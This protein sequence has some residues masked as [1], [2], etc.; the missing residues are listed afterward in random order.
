MALLERYRVLRDTTC[1]YRLS[2][3][4]WDNTGIFSYN[5]FEGFQCKYKTAAVDIDLEDLSKA[6][7]EYLVRCMSDCGITAWLVNWIAADLMERT[8]A[9]SFGT[10]TTEPMQIWPGLSEGSPYRRYCLT[11]IQCT[12]PK[13]NP[14]S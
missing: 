10:G 2:R 12:S 11:Y 5:V 6:N 8:L 1:S 4:T 3:A 9:F 14:L 7:Y 13:Y